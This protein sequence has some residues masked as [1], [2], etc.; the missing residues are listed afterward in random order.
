MVLVIII[1]PLTLSISH[2][3]SVVLFRL[4]FKDPLA[5]KTHQDFKDLAAKKHLNFKDL[6]RCLN[7]SEFQRSRSLSKRI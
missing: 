2:P 5:V 3:P 7:T 1:T 6:A 4:N